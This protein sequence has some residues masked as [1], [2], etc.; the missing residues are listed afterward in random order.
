[1]PISGGTGGPNVQTPNTP[2][3]GS[4]EWRVKKLLADDTA[5]SAPIPAGANRYTVSANDGL[6]A[7]IG[8]GAFVVATPANAARS[9][10]ISYNGANINLVA[11]ALLGT[12]S[13]DAKLSV[14]VFTDGFLYVENRLG[15][16]K[17]VT[18]EFFE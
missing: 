2:R 10:A 16:S 13:T 14:G 4:A 1:M 17:T 5:F 15:A 7:N 11:I 8:E 3:L 9:A 18:V 6:P 12:T